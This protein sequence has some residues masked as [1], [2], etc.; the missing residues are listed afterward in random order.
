[1]LLFVRGNVVAQVQQ[2]PSTCY[3]DNVYLLIYWFISCFTMTVPISTDLSQLLIVL[4]PAIFMQIFITTASWSCKALLIHS[5]FSC[6]SFWCQHLHKQ[7]RSYIILTDRHLFIRLSGV[8]GH[9]SRILH[10]YDGQRYGGKKPNRA[11]TNWTW[12]HSNSISERQ[13]GHKA[14]LVCYLTEWKYRWL[15]ITSLFINTGVFFF[16]R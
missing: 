9:I 3:H 5:P 8:L 12:T 11:S 10:N 6:S 7:S 16:V 13:L 1:M 15:Q 14:S 4:A 2:K